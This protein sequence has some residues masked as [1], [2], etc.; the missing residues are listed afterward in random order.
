ML[1][2]NNY[3][4]VNSNK[5]K[6]YDRGF[7]THHMRDPSSRVINESIRHMINGDLKT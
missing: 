1:S 4:T 2:L 3:E 6:E 5:G 7:A